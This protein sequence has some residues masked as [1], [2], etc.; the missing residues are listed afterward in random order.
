MYHISCFLTAESVDCSTV[1]D[2]KDSLNSNKTCVFPFNWNGT[3]HYSCN[4]DEKKGYW[5]ST[6]VDETGGFIEDKWGICSSK[7]QGTYKYAF[8]CIHSFVILFNSVGRTTNVL[9]LA[10][11]QFMYIKCNFY[12][13]ITIIKSFL[14]IFSCPVKECKTIKV[15]ASSGAIHGTYKMSEERSSNALANPVWKKPG[16]DYYFFNPG[17]NLPWMIGS[18]DDIT[19]KELQSN[20]YQGTIYYQP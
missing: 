12:Q 18:Y 19:T 13:S 9:Y 20:Y 10:N 11:N 2:S 8:N 1:H 4:F 7:C 15:I 14:I 5:C 16:L 17:T 6:E 3:T